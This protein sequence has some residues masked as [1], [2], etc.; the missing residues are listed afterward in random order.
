MNDDEYIGKSTPGTFTRLTT[1]SIGFVRLG[2]VVDPDVLNC[3]VA[4]V[5]GDTEIGVD[6]VGA[7]VGADVGGV[8]AGVGGV[9]AG[10][11]GVGAG[12][13]GVEARSEDRVEVERIVV[14]E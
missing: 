14:E 12:V 5:D 8:G 13:E 2:E 11:G 9:G 7:G 10:V 3:V 1:G 6:G 4:T